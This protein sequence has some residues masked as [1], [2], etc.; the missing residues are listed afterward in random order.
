MIEHNFLPKPPGGMCFACG[1]EN[2][3][4]LQMEF[5]LEQ[6]EFYSQV[7]IRSHHQ[8]WLGIAHGGII[9]TILDETMSWAILYFKRVFFVTKTMEVTF[10]RPVAIGD[11]Y[12]CR[13]RV[14][15]EDGNGIIR[16]QAVLFSSSDKIMARSKGLFRLLS[17]DEMG[18]VSQRDL[19]QMDVW[20]RSLDSFN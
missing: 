3:S 20:F 10:V 18:Q 12:R 13:A 7:R 17:R 6:G 1:M 11:I 14:T 4:G 19:E 5:Y 9:S 2:P 8:G 15:Q 16:A